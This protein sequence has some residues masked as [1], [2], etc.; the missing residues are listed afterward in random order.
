MVVY[1]SCEKTSLMG[2]SFDGCVEKCLY[3]SKDD[4]KEEARRGL[5]GTRVADKTLK[6][7]SGGTEGELPSFAEMVS[8]VAQKVHTVGYF[9]QLNSNLLM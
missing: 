4:V 7:V 3:R 9:L 2:R 8:F 6:E 1:F 5:R